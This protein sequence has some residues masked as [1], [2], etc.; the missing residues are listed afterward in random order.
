VLAQFEGA[1]LNPTIPGLGPLVNACFPLLE[2]QYVADEVINAMK[3]DQAI[4][5]LPRLAMVSSVLKAALPTDLSDT[6]LRV[7]GVTSSMDKFH[8]TRPAQ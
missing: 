2:P 6:I 4:V 1:Q 5:V 8:Q 3:R 7:L